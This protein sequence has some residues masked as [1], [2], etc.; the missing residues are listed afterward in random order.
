[1][2]DFSVSTAQLE[3]AIAAAENMGIIAWFLRTRRAELGLDHGCL[4]CWAGNAALISSRKTARKPSELICASIYTSRVRTSYP[5]AFSGTL[6][7]FE[8]SRWMDTDPPS[9]YVAPAEFSRLR[10]M[11][12]KV[13]ICLPRLMRDVRALGTDDFATD[14]ERSVGAFKCVDAFRRS[15]GRELALA[16]HRAGEDGG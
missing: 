9:V 7:L 2:T 6:S 11:A 13:F 10:K 15:K 12:H 4:T 14:V 3:D 5:P 1:M 16:P 8:E